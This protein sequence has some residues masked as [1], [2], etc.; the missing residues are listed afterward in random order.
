MPTWAATRRLRLLTHG[1]GGATTRR[2]AL[3]LRPRG[4]SCGMGT[5]RDAMGE[6]TQGGD[7]GHELLEHTADVGIR[8]WGATAEEAFEQAAWALVDL[9]GVRSSGP[10][11]PRA[12]RV[13][14][15]DRGVLLADFLNELV[16]LQESEEVGVA[17]IH[18]HLEDGG[19]VAEANVVPLARPPEGATVKAATYHELEVRRAPDGRIEARVYLDV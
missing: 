12:I 5:E 7:A 1:P 2:T 15:A 17:R 8:A 14:A 4:E 19:L 13:E 10:G 16:F 18:V 3:P 6:G 11:E 9:L